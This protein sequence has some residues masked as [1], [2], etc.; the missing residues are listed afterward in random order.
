MLSIIF[1]VAT[2]RNAGGRSYF[3]GMCWFPAGTLRLRNLGRGEVCLLVQTFPGFHSKEFAPAPSTSS[4]VVLRH[5]RHRQHRCNQCRALKNW[6]K[7]PVIC[8]STRVWLLKVIS[9]KSWPC[10]L[11]QPY[12]KSFSQISNWTPYIQI[13]CKLLLLETVHRFLPACMSLY[14][15]LSFQ[16]LWNIPVVDSSGFSR[17]SVVFGF[18]FSPIC[19]RQKEW[20]SRGHV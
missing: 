13:V 12:R 9:N 16:G 19:L 8:C 15:Y 18:R 2:I 3:H 14:L 1:G 17:R 7:S 20:A 4:N 11:V 10:T 5:L 6:R